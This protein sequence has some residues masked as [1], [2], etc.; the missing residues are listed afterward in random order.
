MLAPVASVTNANRIKRC[1]TELGIS[2]SVI[3]TPASL[4]KEGCGYSI[5]FNDSAQNAIAS[6]AGS[7]KIKI[8]S[9]F[10]ESESNGKKVY[11]LV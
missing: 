7:L 5:R 2:A 6:C 10:K 9:Y 11:T 8:R 3:Q 1:V 4:T